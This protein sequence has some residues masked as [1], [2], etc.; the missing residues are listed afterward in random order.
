MGKRVI[1]GVTGSVAATLTHKMAAAM[2]A[3]GHEV[4]VVATT[5]ALYFI[6]EPHAGIYKDKDEWPAGGF[7]KNGPVGHIDMEHWGEVFVIAPLTANTLTKLALGIADN[8]LTCIFYAWTRFRPIVIAP[9]MN[10]DMWKNRLTKEHLER[11][12][13]RYP[14][15][16]IVPPVEKMLACGDIGM[17]A[18]ANIGD[19]VNAIDDVQKLFESHSDWRMED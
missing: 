8:Y 13:R 14:H 16:V 4:R 11:L 18:M 7:I 3:A 1:L 19:I 10:T 15:L 5:P 9:A 12:R 2:V 6:P 17:G